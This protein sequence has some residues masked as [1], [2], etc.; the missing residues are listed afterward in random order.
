MRSHLQ[1]F[2]SALALAAAAVAVAGGAQ[3]AQPM[4]GRD[5]LEVAKV[6]AARYPA[7]P[8]MSYIPALSWSGQLRLST[9][10]GDAHWRVKLVLTSRQMEHCGSSRLV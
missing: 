6:L 8:I 1:K 3:T 2:L 7:Q 5:P 10:T 9:L 4:T